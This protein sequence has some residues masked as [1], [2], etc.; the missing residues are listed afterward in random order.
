M[1]ELGQ[2]LSMFAG[3]AA[4]TL[5]ALGFVL[6]AVA[7]MRGHVRP[8]R[9]SWLIWSVVAALAA[10]GAAPPRL[11]S[12]GATAGGTKSAPG[13]TGSPSLIVSSSSTCRN[14]EER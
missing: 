7:V 3:V 11:D 14:E 5:Q 6:I 2:S 12:A 9:Y 8:N 4:A 10:D 13:G 1:G